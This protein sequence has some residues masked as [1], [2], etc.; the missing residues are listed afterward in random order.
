M[1]VTKIRGI[2]ISACLDVRYTL[3]N[4]ISLQIDARDEI[5]VQNPPVNSKPINLIINITNIIIVNYY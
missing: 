2:A 5:L 3:R 1:G 4:N